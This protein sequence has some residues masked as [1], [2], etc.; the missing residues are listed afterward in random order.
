MS[1]PAPKRLARFDDLKLL[2][3]VD[4]RFARV[5][6]GRDPASGDHVIIHCYDLS[7]APGAL[8]NP[9]SNISYLGFYYCPSW[10]VCRSLIDFFKQ[11]RPIGDTLRQAIPLSA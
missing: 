11:H 9:D 10:R 2:S 1:S 8:A 3:Q 5:F 6:S 4:D 7:A